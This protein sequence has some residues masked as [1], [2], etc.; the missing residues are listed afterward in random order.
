MVDCAEPGINDPPSDLLSARQKDM[1]L[2]S[3]IFRVL[4][5]TTL[6]IW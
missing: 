5:N 3:E 6:A 2:V 1:P 4:E